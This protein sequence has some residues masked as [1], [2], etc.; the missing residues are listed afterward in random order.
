MLNNK[1]QSQSKSFTSKVK[2]RKQN[3]YLYGNILEL[4]K[5]GMYNSQIADKLKMSKQRVNYYLKNLERLKFIKEDIRSSYKTYKVTGE[6]NKFIS[7]LKSNITSQSFSLGMRQDS[8]RSHNFRVKFKILKDN[9]KAK[10]E[11]EIKLN[12]WIKKTKKINIPFNLTIEKTNKNII[13]IFSNIISDLRTHHN[14]LD[15]FKRKAEYYAYYYLKDHLGVVIDILSGKTIN[16]HIGTNA[17]QLKQKADPKETIEIDLKR[18]SQSV[19]PTD[20]NAKV[21]IDRSKKFLEQETND[22]SYMMKMAMMPESIHEFTEKTVPLFESW[23]NNLILHFEVLKEIS[24]TMKQIQK[25]LPKSK[26]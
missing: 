4:L 20:I 21:W 13:L 19:Y 23:N 8:V 10:W 9:K 6:G 14:K 16:H 18:K 2:I 25:N 3:F 11:K 17:D 22:L 24:E 15:D 5:K 1:Q 7:Q 26:Q 12:N